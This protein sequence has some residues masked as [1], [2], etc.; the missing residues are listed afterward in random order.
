MGLPSIFR[1]TPAP[2]ADVTDDGL[3][4]VVDGH[5]LHLDGLLA[6]G[7]VFLEGLDLARERA[8]EL[9]RAKTA[10]RR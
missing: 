1:R 4:A 5:V 2:L 9:V 3:A 10:P 7:A 8:R 6:T